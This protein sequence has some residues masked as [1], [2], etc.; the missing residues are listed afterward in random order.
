MV[1]IPQKREGLSLF[2]IISRRCKTVNGVKFLRNMFR[3]PTRDLSIILTRQKAVAYFAKPDRYELCKVFQDCMRCIKNIH[4]IL[5]KLSFNHAS[6]KD[7][8][9]L[10]L[11][12]L[13]M[14]ILVE[15]CVRQVKDFTAN[16]DVELLTQ[17]ASLAALPDLHQAITAIEN[18]FDVEE[19][20]R[21]D[22][23]VVLPGMDRQVCVL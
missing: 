20:Q 9:C 2:N 4:R 16:D 7:W 19:S 12:L 21:R 5:K 15:M 3:S 22:A 17:I 8:K 6:V 13:H 14:M 18:V 11:T 1:L 10:K 23:F